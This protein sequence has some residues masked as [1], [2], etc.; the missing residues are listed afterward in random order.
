MILTFKHFNVSDECTTYT[1]PQCLT[2]CEST[3]RLL[4]RFNEDSTCPCKCNCPDFIE[5]DCENK[6]QK[7]GK[8]TKLGFTDQFGCLRCKCACPPYH[9]TS[10]QNQ[11]IQEDKIHIVG[12]KSRFECDICQCGCL[13]RDCDTECGDLE[14]RVTTGSQGCIVGCQCICSDDCEPNCHGC[15]PGN[16]L[17]FFTMI[18]SDIIWCTIR[19]QYCQ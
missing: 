2:K 6:C 9:N 5:A 8:V 16:N 13:N 12:A 1:E 18:L 3:N 4:G 17:H 11:C 7:E 14:P 10:C 19:S 15:I